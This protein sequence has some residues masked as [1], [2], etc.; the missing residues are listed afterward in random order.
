MYFFSHPQKLWIQYITPGVL[1]KLSAVSNPVLLIGG[2]ND[3]VV[4]P[5]NVRLMAQRIP[6][7]WLS[8]FPG[9]HGA[10]LEWGTA[11][12]TLF[13]DFYSVYGV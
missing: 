4:P 11:F 7:T 8:I 12:T 13:E 6:K 2:L 3:P 10:L 9:R 1:G 5:A